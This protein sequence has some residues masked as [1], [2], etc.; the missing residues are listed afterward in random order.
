MTPPG[1]LCA[2][3]EPTRDPCGT[4]SGAKEPE[5]HGRAG[6]AGQASVPMSVGMRAMVESK[7]PWF[8]TGEIPTTWCDSIFRVLS[9]R[10]GLVSRVG[11]R[12]TGHPCG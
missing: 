7:P 4:D 6:E 3:Q 1:A 11:R 10:A 12:S 5:Q 8:P 9:A 2:R